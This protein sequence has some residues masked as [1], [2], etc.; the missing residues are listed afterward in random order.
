MEC[1]SLLKKNEDLCRPQ[2]GQTWKIWKVKESNTK[3]HIKLIHLYDKSRIGESIETESW[4]VV[5][6]AGGTEKL[7][8]HGIPFWGHENCL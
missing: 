2:H 7:T 8:E 1:Y 5:V 6:W 4:S 3:G